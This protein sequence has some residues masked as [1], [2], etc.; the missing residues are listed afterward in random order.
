MQ[1]KKLKVKIKDAQWQQLDH[2]DK[3]KYTKEGEVWHLSLG[4]TR[5]L[6]KAYN[7]AEKFILLV[8]C[9]L[10]HRH[11]LTKELGLTTSKKE[12]LIF[13]LGFDTPTLK[14]NHYSGLTGLKLITEVITKK[15][16]QKDDGTEKE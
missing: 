6:L 2:G 13:R 15:T 1:E 12:A 5:A 8:D 16:K 4:K 11:Y 9:K 7:R 10:P 14:E 3:L